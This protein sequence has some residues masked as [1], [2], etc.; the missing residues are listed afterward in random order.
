MASRSAARRA[1]L[2]AAGIPIELRADLDER[3]RSG[4]R[5]V[6][7]GTATA[8]ETMSA[9]VRSHKCTSEAELGRTSSH[10]KR[11]D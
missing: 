11:I 10:Y 9:G 6:L 3:A 2:E 1:V 5:F 4:R 8:S 7:R